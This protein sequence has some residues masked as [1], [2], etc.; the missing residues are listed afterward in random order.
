MD[1]INR[2][3]QHLADRQYEECLSVCQ[4]ILQTEPRNAAACHC[5]GMA[6]FHMGAMQEAADLIR[7]AI[8]INGKVIEYQADLCLVL[9]TAGD[10][11]GAIRIQ[12]RIIK[13]A[14]DHPR[15]LYGLGIMHL[16]LNE[17]SNAAKALS[18]AARLV[19]NEPEI[20]ATLGIALQQLDKMEEAIDAYQKA[21][22]LGSI[23]PNVF[24]NLG[25]AYAKERQD[26]AALQSYHKAIELDQN[27]RLAYRNIGNLLQNNGDCLR[28]IPYM[29]QA[30]EL[31]PDDAETRME[32]HS[33]L[34]LSGQYEE[35]I[36]YFRESVKAQPDSSDLWNKLAFSYLCNHQ[37]RP[38]LQAALKSLQIAPSN[39][40][41]LCQIAVAYNE[42]GERDKAAFYLDF[43]RLIY[44]KTC[45]PPDGFDTIEDFNKAFTT[46]IQQESDLQYRLSNRTL[47]DGQC[48]LD[49]FD[50]KM[51][52][53]VARFNSMVKLAFEEYKR[54]HPVD[55]SHPFLRTHPK[56]KRIFCWANV[57]NEH[58]FHCT[59][60]HPSGWVSGVYYPS[61]PASVSEDDPDHK[62]WIE[63]GRA[64]NAFRSTDEPPVRNVRPTPG[65]MVLFPSYFGHRTIPC[66]IEPGRISVA[67][68]FEIGD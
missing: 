60:Y 26:M 30:L 50:G 58:G 38:A 63:F 8:S 46:Y 7:R 15:H 9:Y 22:S 21:V 1:P 11:R 47:A 10:V 19:P 54:D 33:A 6:R 41:G 51:P 49:L 52:P 53:V 17:F 28:A 43:D 2:A 64:D 31:D 13:S 35:P 62:G 67:F 65:T 40:T 12:Q 39:T 5:S 20:Q 27:Y 42:V 61:I 23:D 25:T 18:K 36:D 56:I 57:M 44:V 14:P 16:T 37:A 55:P 59:H 4:S 29:R 45:Q 32:L 3:K 34:S 66:E 48:T 24:Y 68:D